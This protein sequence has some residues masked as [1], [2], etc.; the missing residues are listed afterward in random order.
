[1][2]SYDRGILRALSGKVG[3]VIGA[4]WRGIDYMRSMP[5]T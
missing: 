5:I 2:G 4:H 3:S 1:M